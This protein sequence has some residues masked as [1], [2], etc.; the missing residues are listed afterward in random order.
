MLR[1]SISRRDCLTIMGAGTGAAAATRRDGTKSTEDAVKDAFP[2]V[3][4]SGD[5]YQMGYQ[6]GSQASDLIQRYLRWIEKMTRRP[7]SELCANAMRFLPYIE[8]LSHKF[9]QEVSG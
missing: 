1:S 4:V 3:E 9:V 2:L 7:R 5:A 8:T 6:H